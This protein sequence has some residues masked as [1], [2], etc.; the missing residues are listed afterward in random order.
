MLCKWKHNHRKMF[1][2]RRSL[3]RWVHQSLSRLVYQLCITGNKSVTGSLKLIDLFA[4]FQSKPMFVPSSHFRQS[5][6][7]TKNILRN[8]STKSKRYDIIHLSSFIVV[9]S[10]DSLYV[11]SRNGLKALWLSSIALNSFVLKS[12]F[13]TRLFGILSFCLSVCIFHTW[14]NI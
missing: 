12:V 13:E 5:T 10:H 3:F 4:R 2:Y 14:W 1:A 9:Q 7:A 6:W 11:L 8:I